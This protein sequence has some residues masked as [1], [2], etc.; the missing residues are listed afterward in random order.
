MTAKTGSAGLIRL[1]FGCRGR[2]FAY[3]SLVPTVRIAIIGLAILEPTVLV[4]M[5]GLVSF[6]PI[7]FVPMVGLANSFFDPALPEPGWLKPKSFFL[8]SLIGFFVD[9]MLPSF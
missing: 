1:D 7:V 8:S 6:V 4:A 5:I 2:S 9:F 3:T